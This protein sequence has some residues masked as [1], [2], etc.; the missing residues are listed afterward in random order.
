MSPRRTS[1]QGRNPRTKGTRPGTHVPVLL[2]QVLRIADPQPGQTVADCTLGYGGHA[3]RIAQRIGKTGHLVG[4]DLDGRQLEKTAGR[5]EQLPPKISLH[6]RNYAELPDVMAAERISGFDL[7][8]ADLGVSSMQI[9]DEGRGIGYATD[10]PLDM[11]M[12]AQAGI[13]T[14]ADLLAEMPATELA[15]ALADLSDEPDAV[16]IAQ[17]IVNQRQALPIATTGQLVRLVLAAK[18]LTEKTWKKSEKSGYGKFHP[19][20]RTFQALRILVNDELASLQRLLEALPDCLA[21][22]G[23]VMVISFQPG[24]DRL[25]RSAFQAGLEEGLYCR[26]N[27]EAITPSGKEIHRNWRASSGRLRWALRA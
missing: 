24:E 7:V 8:L 27:R 25:V 1:R 12:D 11:R 6:H 15:G 14:G 22:G 2:G 3:V 9:D 18:G 4:L 10:G 26:I 19:A 23:R 17:W 16:T 20:A 5:L 13:P 21:R